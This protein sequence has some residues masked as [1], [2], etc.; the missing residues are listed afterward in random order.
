V[1]VKGLTT[2]VTAIAVGGYTACAVTASGGVE[3]WGDNSFGQLGNNS[4]ASSL[5]PVPVQGLTKGVTAISVG[6]TSACAVTGGGGAVCWGDNSQGQL[7]SG[8]T[9]SSLVPVP[10]QG[11]TSGVTAVSVGGAAACALQ[12]GGAISCWGQP[13]LGTGVA[14]ATTVPTPLPAFASGATAISLGS[15]TGCAIGAGGHVEC[16]G[17]NADGA[18][19]SGAVGSATLAPGPVAGF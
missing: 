17:N 16:W 15:Y 5:V 14:Q 4:M 12:A 10:V 9:T 8:L 11:I 6:G 7:G 18:L 2:G 1:Q 13:P 19:G 3:C